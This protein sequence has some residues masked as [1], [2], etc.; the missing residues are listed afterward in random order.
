MK[1]CGYTYSRDD[2][3]S[4]D[5]HRG[6]SRYEVGILILLLLSFRIR[7]TFRNANDTVCSPTRK[8]RVPSQTLPLKYFDR[9]AG[10][11][12]VEKLSNQSLEYKMYGP[13]VQQ[14]SGTC[15][16][17]T[18]LRIVLWLLYNIIVP[19]TLQ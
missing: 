8:C 6:L 12:A 2:A 14:R 1:S 11:S 7:K 5:S 9:I 19:R 4:R 15:V 18:G 17:T 13:Y 16:V 10:R 3:C